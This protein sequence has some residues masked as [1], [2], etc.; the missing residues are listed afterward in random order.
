MPARRS[1]VSVRGPGWGKGGEGERGGRESEGTHKGTPPFSPRGARAARRVLVLL[2]QSHITVVC[3]LAGVVVWSNKQPVA[4]AGEAHWRGGELCSSSTGATAG[5]AGKPPP[6]SGAV[7]CVR[8]ECAVPCPCG[9][10]RVRE[11]AQ[12][13]KQVC[14][15]D[16]N[17]ISSHL[18]KLN[19]HTAPLPAWRPVWARPPTPALHHRQKKHGRALPRWHHAPPTRH[20]T[21][22]RSRPGHRR[23]RAV[24]PGHGVAAGGRVAERSGEGEG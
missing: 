18:H 7:T 12:R 20:A 3:E 14:E 22:R 2:A 16:D 24:R 21:P 13:E 10:W 4:V 23:R 5:H 8:C 15:C 9:A 19:S 11:E 1:A 6:A 17:N